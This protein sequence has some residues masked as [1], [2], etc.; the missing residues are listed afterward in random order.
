MQTTFCNNQNR[1]EKIKVPLDRRPGVVYEIKCGCHASYIGETGKG[2]LDRF[3]EHT[4]ALARYKTAKR[5]LNGLPAQRRGRPQTRDPTKIMDEAIKA[6]AVVEHGSTCPLEL[7]PRIVCREV[8]FH[9]RR[10]KEALYIR[11]NPSLSRDKGVQFTEVWNTI[12]N[13]TRCCILPT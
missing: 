3:H 4:A 2:L 11:H 5:R 10:I 1:S 6:S 12:I 13:I 8:R 9:L 7:Q